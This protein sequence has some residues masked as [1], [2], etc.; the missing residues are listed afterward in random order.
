MTR[1]RASRGCVHGISARL[2]CGECIDLAVM[3]E[4]EACARLVSRA[5]LGSPSPIDGL[6]GMNLDEMNETAMV[7]IH[8]ACQAL[9]SAIRDRSLIAK[10]EGKS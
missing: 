2:H 4:R 5:S 8:G 6:G 1:K 9:A 3:V 7:A 10:A